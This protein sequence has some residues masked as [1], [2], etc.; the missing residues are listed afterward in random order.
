MSAMDKLDDSLLSTRL[1]CSGYHPE[2]KLQGSAGIAAAP[3]AIWSEFALPTRQ[4]P[5]DIKQLPD[6]DS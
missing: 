4:L 3:A 1:W 5:A 6:L 2:S